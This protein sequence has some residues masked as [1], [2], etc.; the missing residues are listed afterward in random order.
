MITKSVYN[1]LWDNLL[2]GAI[3]I[4]LIFLT[5]MVIQKPGKIKLLTHYPMVTATTLS[6]VRLRKAKPSISS[7]NMTNFMTKVYSSPNM[8]TISSSAKKIHY[9][10][11]R[12]QVNTNVRTNIMDLFIFIKQLVEISYYS[13]CVKGYI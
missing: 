3:I 2:F 8:V 6:M 11:K 5:I 13:Y 9:S 1:P 4:G 7:S 12:K 10:Y